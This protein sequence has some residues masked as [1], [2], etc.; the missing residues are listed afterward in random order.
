MLVLDV[1]QSD[2][3][4]YVCIIGVCYIYIYIYILFQTLFHFGDYKILNAVSHA[5]S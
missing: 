1:Q 4:I 3:V 2:S 5:I